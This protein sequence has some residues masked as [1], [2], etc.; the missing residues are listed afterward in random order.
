MGISPDYGDTP[1]SGDELDALL[2]TLAELLGATKDK[3]ALY[4][5][6][7]AIHVNVAQ[8]LMDDAINGR[9]AVDAIVTG[10]F[11]RELHWELYGEIWTWAGAF[12][13]HEINLGVAPEQIP[14]ETASSLDTLIYRW[15]NTADWSS[16]QIGISVHAEILRIHPFADGNGRTS[17]LVADLVFL[18]TQDNDS[19]YLYEWRIDKPRYI[20][21]LRECDQHR[22]PIFL[23]EFIPIRSLVD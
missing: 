20:S 17:R 23:A 13:R 7:Q 19:V 4:D 12:R 18:S 3:S 8:K 21:L 14:A 15:R 16:R 5:F 10:R 11:I 6:E 2:P 9:L 22:N 1:L